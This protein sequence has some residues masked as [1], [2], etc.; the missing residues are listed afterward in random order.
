MR[1]AILTN[2]RRGEAS[3]CLQALVEHPGIEIAAVVFCQRHVDRRAQ[4]R[5]D[6]KKLR[7]VGLA[8]AVIGYSM[9]SWYVTPPGEELR[10]VC[11]RHEIPFLVSPYTNSEGTVSRLRTSQAELGISLGNGWISPEVFTVPPFGMINVHGEVLPRFR[12]AASVIWAIY[13]G[14]PETGFTIHEIDR[15]ID[16]GRILYQERFPIRFLPTLEETV[17]SNVRSI[18]QLVPRALTTVVA[19]FKAYRDA[20]EPQVGGRSYTTP[21]L[22]QFLQMRREFARLRAEAETRTQN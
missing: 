9:R 2:A 12:G 3:R 5:R 18:S 17:R 16:T 19:N 14:V 1:I 4:I 8:G 13:E 10:A 21:T 20:A 11:E 22:R 6:I 7:K 15:S